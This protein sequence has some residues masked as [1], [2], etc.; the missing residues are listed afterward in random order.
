MGHIA[1]HVLCKR[2][3]RRLVPFEIS[4]DIQPCGCCPVFIIVSDGSQIGLLP[5][6]EFELVALTGESHEH[7]GNEFPSAGI[8]HTHR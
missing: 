4:I 6:H 3:E 5:L 8:H 7:N 2:L 1:I